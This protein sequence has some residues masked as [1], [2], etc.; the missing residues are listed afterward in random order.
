MTGVRLSEA[1]R[2]LLAQEPRPVSKR[3]VV[4]ARRTY[5]RAYAPWGRV[6]EFL[7]LRLTVGGLSEAEVG[8]V[9]QR[10]PQAVEA[11]LKKLA[12]EFGT[13][14]EAAARL[15]RALALPLGGPEE[16]APPG[17][18]TC[19]YCTA[20]VPAGKSACPS[21]GSPV[22]TGS[23]PA[24]PAGAHHLPV[25]TTLQGG[26][27]SLGRVLGEGGFG[28]T[29][30]GANVGLRQRVAVKELFPPGATRQG[31]SLVAPRG[32][33]ADGLAAERAKFVA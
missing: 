30:G 28:I 5:R 32:G 33:P 16:P 23:A 7:L 26:K 27:Y 2:Y 9:V 17:A 13:V 31:R 25:G 24:A 20:S 22:R 11:R 10:Q 1:E 21:C 4:A 3:E 12:K 18:Q 29:Y 6:E 8:K 15:S 14:S 19:P